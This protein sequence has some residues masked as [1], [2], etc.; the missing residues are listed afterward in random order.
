MKFKE[1]GVKEELN[2]DIIKEVELR[3]VDIWIDNYKVI[4]KE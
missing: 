3:I 1:N 2:A 4:A